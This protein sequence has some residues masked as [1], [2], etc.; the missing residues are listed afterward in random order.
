MLKIFTYL[1]ICLSLYGCASG[2]IRTSDFT[3]QADKQSTEALVLKQA[4]QC[5]QKRVDPVRKGIHV[6]ASRKSEFE[7]V[8]SAYRVEWAGPQPKDAFITVSIKTLDSPPRVTVNEG[9]FTCGIYNGC[10]N[11][12]LSEDVSNWLSGNLS[13]KNI[14]K[15]LLALGL[16]F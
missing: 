2:P 7:S 3:T 16:G 1:L 12:N 14:D 11:L 6:I 13:C 8:V 5:W 9:D 15:M 10:V 4:Q